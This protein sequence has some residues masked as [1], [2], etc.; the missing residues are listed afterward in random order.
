MTAAV[1]VVLARTLDGA[2]LLGLVESGTRGLDVERRQPVDRTRNLGRL[3]L[4]QVELPAANVIAVDDAAARGVEAIGRAIER[5][6]GVDV[7][8]FVDFDEGGGGFQISDPDLPEPVLFVYKG[9][10]AVIGYGEGAATDGLGTTST[11]GD[12]QRYSD[13][14][15][16]LGDGYTGSL[17]LDA[18]PVLQ[19]IENLAGTDPGYQQARPYLE[20]FDFIAGG[21][22]QE[23][24]AVRTKTLIKLK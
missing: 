22:K 10:R 6:G 1:F 9:S 15:G 13:A 24:D 8:R 2:P 18:A 21:T 5:Q 11:L 3:T 19:L 7:E 14:I 23:G 12:Q 17:F 16:A 20:P 4:A